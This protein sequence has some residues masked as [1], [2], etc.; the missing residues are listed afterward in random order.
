MYNLS[1]S[2][3]DSSESVSNP[4][5]LRCAQQPPQQLRNENPN[6]VQGRSGMPNRP[7]RESRQSPMWAIMKGTISIAEL[8]SKLKKIILS[9]LV[10][11]IYESKYAVLCSTSVNS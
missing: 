10:C 8:I 3:S 11:E 4:R 9:V 2:D 5:N 6:A 1:H 7:Q